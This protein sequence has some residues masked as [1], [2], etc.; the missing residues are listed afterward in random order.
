MFPSGVPT[1][2]LGSE[3]YKLNLRSVFIN[4]YY[5]FL[6]MCSP[7]FFWWYFAS[8]ANHLCK[9]STKDLGFFIEEKSVAF[10]VTA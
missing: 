3:V 2:T 8:R 5:R 4:P 7:D 6:H 1:G 9:H 10:Q